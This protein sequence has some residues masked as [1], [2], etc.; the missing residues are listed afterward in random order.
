MNQTKQHPRAREMGLIGGEFTT[1]PPPYGYVRVIH[2]KD[3]N[4]RDCVCSYAVTESSSPRYE[5]P[6]RGKVAEIL[7]QAL[8]QANVTGRTPD[9]L[10]E[11]I[12]DLKVA[13]ATAKVLLDE[14]MIGTG[15]QLDRV[16][17]MV[18]DIP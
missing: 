3:Q 18:K 1:T 13:C 7:A 4:P 17:N 9:E 8:T 11:L 15:K 2:R 16:L 14:H 12:R 10:V 6:A 5:I